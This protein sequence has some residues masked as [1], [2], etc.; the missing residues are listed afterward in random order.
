MNTV[1]TAFQR[2]SQMRA[3][4]RLEALTLAWMVV[5]AG[6]SIGAGLAA[7]SLLLIAFGAD[8]VVEMLSAGVLYRRLCREAAFP[9]A[10]QA[11]LE[12][13]ERRT[14]RIAGSLLYALA[15]CV[16]LQ[17]LYG[18][19]HRHTAEASWWGL[20][21]AVIAAVGMP[22]LAKAK[23]RVADSIGSR[24]LRADAMESLTCGY[25][26]WLLFLGLLTNA[27]LHWWWLDS[28]AVLLLIPFL[29]NEG[30][31]AIT[32]ECGCHGNLE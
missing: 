24:A 28:V 21:V 13:L 4:L 11:D 19:L 18:L 9:F 7:H 2:D 14:A 30:R 5:E 12:S 27:L 29:I 6:A 26:A 3:A 8:S 16:F 25:L 23:I 17:S 22:L 20:A 1:N 31:E 15:L 32:G 10:D